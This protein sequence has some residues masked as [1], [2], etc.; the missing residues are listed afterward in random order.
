MTSVMKCNQATKLDHC[1]KRLSF[2]NTYVHKKRFKFNLSG[3]KA[4]EFELLI[5]AKID[6]V[7]WL[8]YIGD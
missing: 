8:S 1:I 3:S 2:G 4:N 6:H 7:G 5:W